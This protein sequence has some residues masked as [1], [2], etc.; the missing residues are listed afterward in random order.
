[1]IATAKLRHLRGSAQKARLVIDQVRGKSVE[2]AQHILT[3]S[4]R[5]AARAIKKVVD[6]AVANAQVKDPKL[7]VDELV[8]TKAVVDEGP[9]MKR[10]RHRS[11][12]RV[13]TI[14]KRTCH[15]TIG[16]DVKG[17]GEAS[18]AGGR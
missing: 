11:M 15:V 10:I 1:V 5:S 6:S 3:Y 8:V 18:S 13:Y 4:P 17:G 14:L 12:G 7:D 9:H 2:E 16:L